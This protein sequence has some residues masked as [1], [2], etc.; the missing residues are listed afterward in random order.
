MHILILGPTGQVGG[1]LVEE[2]SNATDFTI[3][4]MGRSNAEVN[5]DFDN[6]NTIPTHLT[7][8]NPDLIINAIAYTAVDKAESDSEA[9][10]KINGDLPSVLSDWCEQNNKQLI[11]YSTDFVFD[12]Q[13]AERWNEWDECQPLSIYGKT[14]LAG[15]KAI[16]LTSASAIILRTSWVYGETGNNFMKTMVRL[17]KD[18]ESL[19]V[20][21]DQRGCPTY[22]RDLA[23]ATVSII[24]QYAADSEP[25]SGRQLIYHL[26]GLGETTW[27]GF[28][29]AIFE[30]AGK[31]E[32]LAIQTLNPITTPDYPTPACRPPNSVM[33]CDEIKNDLGISMPAWEASLEEA[34]SRLYS[35]HS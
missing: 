2:I 3:T 16:Q 22:S 19:G 29:K 14:K 1:M 20:V 18:R 33:S 21:N 27:Y 5:V 35:E 6:L 4:T 26:C 32:S 24:E 15:E 12:G 7:Q 28:A 8:I 25:F 11:H 17:A 34:V 23:R 30:L 9:A 31:Y 10:F 13:K